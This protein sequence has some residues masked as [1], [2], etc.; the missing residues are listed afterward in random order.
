MRQHRHFILPM[1]NDRTVTHAG[2][3]IHRARNVITHALDDIGHSSI[4]WRKYIP[5]EGVVILIVLSLAAMSF[6]IRTHAEQVE[7]KPLV[8][9]IMM[10]VQLAG[11][12][13]PKDQPAIP[14]WQR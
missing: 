12:A 3:W 8:R 2:E 5:A 9:H 6:L 7:G 4:G 11:I 1:L 10:M 13:A 14:K